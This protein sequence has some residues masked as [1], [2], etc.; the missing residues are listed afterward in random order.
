MLRRFR[1]DVG[2]AV[3]RRAHAI[4]CAV[5]FIVGSLLAVAG[6]DLY[7]QVLDPWL[8]RLAQARARR[9]EHRKTLY[10]RAWR[11]AREVED[12]GYATDDAQMTLLGFV[13]VNA[14]VKVV[15]TREK[16][17]SIGT[18][19]AALAEASMPPAR[20]TRTSGGEGEALT[21]VRARTKS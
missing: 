13:L 10:W 1:G 2:R 6:R 15:P 11:A 7:R 16:L 8:R 5:A 4:V 12:F 18:A 9:P 17:E 3:S 19:W 14:L 20:S 21:A